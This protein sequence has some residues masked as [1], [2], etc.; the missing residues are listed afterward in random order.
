M[1]PR[2]LETP[3]DVV[4]GGQEAVSGADVAVE[5]DVAGVSGLVDDESQVAVVVRDRQPLLDVLGVE[6]GR[7]VGRHLDGDRAE[8]RA[9]VVDGRDGHG[10]VFIAHIDDPDEALLRRM[11]CGTKQRDVVAVAAARQVR[12]VSRRAFQ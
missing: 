5:L 10:A 3:G 9:G 12:E 7:A 1:A 8:R 2:P 6:V 4:H 11:G